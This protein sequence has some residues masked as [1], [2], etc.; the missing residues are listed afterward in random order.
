M[1]KETDNIPIPEPVPDK[2][3]PISVKDRIK[4][5]SNPCRPFNEEKGCKKIIF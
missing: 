3:K 4:S 2:T 5:S 1:K